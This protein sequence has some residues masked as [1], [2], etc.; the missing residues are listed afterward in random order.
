M[1]AQRCLDGDRDPSGTSEVGMTLP[2]VMVVDDDSITATVIAEVLRDQADIVLVPDGTQAHDRAVGLR[3]DLI[4]LDVMMPGTDGYLICGRLKEDPRT[5]DIPVIF[6]SSLSDEAQEARGLLA[7]AVDYVSKPISAPILTARVR[8]HLELKRQRDR[9]ERESLRDDLTGLGNRTRLEDALNSEWRRA[10]RLKGPVSL[11]VVAVDGFESFSR[12]YGPLATRECLRK[13]GAALAASAQR[14]GDIV[15]R[16]PP[17]RFL[18]IL[19]DTDAKGALAVAERMRAAVRLLDVPHA[20]AGP[21]ATMTV[22]VAVSTCQPSPGEHPAFALEQV[23]EGLAESQQLGRDRCVSLQ[24][25]PAPK[26]EGPRVAPAAAVQ[27]RLL[28]VDDDPVSVQ[29]LSELVRSAGYGVQTLEDSTGA[30]GQ[31]QATLPD[32]IL[33]DLRMPGIDGFEVCRRL[34]RNPLT[35]AIPVVF[36]SIVDDPAE[37]LRAFEVGG[38]DY[39]GKNFHPE[40]VLARIG[41]QIKITRLQREMAEANQRLLELDRMKATFAAM[42]VHDLRSPLGVVQVTLGLLQEKVAESADPDLPEL[43]DLSMSGL[44]STV[45]LINELLEIYRS[46]QTMVAPVRERIDVAEIVRRCAGEARLDAQR[47]QVVLDVAVTGPLPGLGDRTRLERA[48]TNLIGNALKFTRAGG[49]IAIQAAPARA[50]GRKVLRVQVRDNGMGIPEE[51]IPYIFD[52]YRQVETGRRSGVGLGLAIVKRILDAHGGSIAV[53][54]QLGVGS[55]FTVDLPA[56]P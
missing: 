55:A 6:V 14:P 5:R 43:L 30:V 41:H 2:T 39:V 19:P 54:S 53:A 46:E 44:K 27:G 21:E 8:N 29:V 50:D 28:V 16:F 52:L 34:K 9:L 3:P 49:H 23:M 35:A 42:L 37:K 17:D 48:F 18:A 15:G 12:L 47:R 7:G 51:E 20:E 4:L 11:M 25:E 56:A 38:A 1:L 32:L 10:A 13:V 40:E 33:L 26:P 36:L 22:S 45:A 24:G 31:A